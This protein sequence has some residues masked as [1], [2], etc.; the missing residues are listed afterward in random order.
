MNI[1]SSIPQNRALTYIMLLCLLPILFV[2]IHFFS[3]LGDI[4]QL[5][6]RLNYVQS[7]AVLKEQKQAQ[8]MQIWNHYKSADHFYIDKYLESLTF[9]E[10][11]VDALQ[12][13]ISQKNFPDD[14]AIK[15]RLEFL[16]GSGNQ[17]TFSEGAVVSYPFFQETVE[18]L[19]H[20]V[21]INVDDLKNILSRVDG[22]TIGPYTPPAGRPQLIVLDLKLEKKKTNDKS[23]VYQLNMKLLKREYQG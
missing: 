17:L 14:E 7:T 4:E 6:A 10:P 3:S 12:K 5:E 15:K 2:I 8:N 9:L 11:E 22:V 18:T 1:L 19:V 20:P 23:E 21:E 13:I 16:T